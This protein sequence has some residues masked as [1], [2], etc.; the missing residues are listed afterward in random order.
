MLANAPT[1]EAATIRATRMG[2]FA[3]FGHDRVDG[4]RL[5]G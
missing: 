2:R 1:V 4:S 5:I 3:I